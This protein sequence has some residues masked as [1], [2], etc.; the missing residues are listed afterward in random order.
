MLQF[1][2]EEPTVFLLLVPRGGM[3][4]ATELATL[5][6]HCT[7]TAYGYPA[8]EH[9]VAHLLVNGLEYSSQN[10]EWPFFELLKKNLSHYGISAVFHFESLHPQTV[11]TF[12]LLISM[13]T[14]P[15]PEVILFLHVIQI[16][17]IYKIL[18]DF[19]YKA[20]MKRFGE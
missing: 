8:S 10:D 15:Y 6:V 2:E 4:V 14:S 9:H 16:V 12:T 17:E 11:K 7:L 18:T 19:C 13:T 1:T 3:P 20:H 5:L